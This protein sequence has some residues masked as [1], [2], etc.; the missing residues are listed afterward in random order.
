MGKW[1]KL[2][3]ANL[4]KSVDVQKLYKNTFL[5]LEEMGR[6]VTL[7]YIYLF[8]FAII[9]FVFCPDIVISRCSLK[10]CS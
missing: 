7:F 4:E 8:H 10:K 9:I 3:R 6:D 5:K 1:K 2:Q